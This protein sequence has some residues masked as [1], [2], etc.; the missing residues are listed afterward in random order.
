MATIPA[1]TANT[2]STA[3]SPGEDILF[4]NT[5][6]Q[7]IF[8][9][10]DYKMEKSSEP[11]NLTG[12][13][14]NLSFSSFST[15]ENMGVDDFNPKI[16]TSVQNNELRPAPSDPHS[17]SYFG[18][19]YTE[20]ARSINNIIDT[21]PY[22]ALAFDG[23]NGN[24][25][26]DYTETT[27]LI[28]GE[29][30][31]NFKIPASVITNQG[32]I[33]FNSASTVGNQSSLMTETNQF[34][35][36]F[37]GVSSANTESFE[38]DSY[39]F[40]GGTSGVLEFTLKGSLKNSVNTSGFTAG[41]SNLPIY[42]RPSK[43]RATVYNMQK[44]RLDKQLLEVGLLDIP[45][46]DDEHKNFRY[47]I[48]WPRTIDGFNPDITGDVFETYK[49]NILLLAGNVDVDKTDVMI[50]T[51][52]P[53]NYLDF[54]TDTQI[55][56]KLT[57]S[58]AKQFDEIKQFIDNIAYAHTMNYNNENSIP[59]KF[60]V[61]FS[62]LLGWK[63]SSSFSEID[64][65]EYLADDENPEQNSFAYYNVELWKRILIN[66]NWLY[67]KKG[68]RDAIQFLFKLMGAPDCLIE[69]NE[70]VYDINKTVVGD[71]SQE[72]GS[73]A[74]AL[75][76]TSEI[77]KINERGFINYDASKFIFQEGGAGRGDGQSY[78]NQWRP[79]FN[80]LK[81]VDNIKVQVGLTAFTGS[82]NI[83]NT[84]EVQI[85]L[86]SA[87]AVECD[88][89]E[90][91]QL[92]GTCW[93]W[94]T[95]GSPTFDGNN[96]PFEYTIPNC[97]FVNPD[98]I[99]GMTFSE[100]MEFIYTSNIEPRNRKTNT[101]SHTT[102]A[103]PE[104]KR[105]YMNY[106]LLA[107][108]KSNSLNIKKLESFLDLIAIN[109]EEY[110]LQLIPATTILNAGSIVY[111]N[112]VFHRQRFVYKEGIND[113]SEFK[114]ALPPNLNSQTY[115]VNVSAQINDFIRAGA[116]VVSINS[117]I[118]GGVDMCINPANITMTVNQNSLNSVVDSFEVT[119]KIE[120]SISKSTIFPK[121]L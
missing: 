55:Y 105:I 32:F 14:E 73:E 85:Q 53:D 42:I 4:G 80:P 95:Q 93:V 77:S 113:G 63:L 12:T 57:S 35:I 76:E 111:R 69:F 3:F 23:Y 54:D 39:S 16:Y 40:T 118:S 88:V 41:T 34:E 65:F 36:Q 17:Y 92:S 74:E 8:T 109:F 82:E 22:A 94:G 10:G 81:R 70:F 30:T 37:S 68:T 20:V 56:R 115:P 26:Y 103:Y 67:K 28:T 110:V 43:K 72:S 116:N 90:W 59:E 38:I 102:W 11:D 25:V 89:F 79:E 117:S 78:I 60:L 52:I 1:N 100:Y 112:T 71:I 86:N 83:I 51:M 98:N 47:N 84:K 108:P 119:N 6:S 13:S 15:L 64:L 114:K 61:K 45:D 62:N 33:L 2:L 99:T 48:P 96:V 121:S 120:P 27:N 21:F 5:S 18:S 9:H 58:Y 7:A 75:T 31:S 106:Y 29:Q 97:D 104:L 91:Y 44:P 50:K 66:I 101:Q 19:F 49:D 107:E 24:T 87:Q 46:V